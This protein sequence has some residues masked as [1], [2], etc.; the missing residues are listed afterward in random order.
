MLEKTIST[1]LVTY[2]DQTKW[3]YFLVEDDDLLEKYNIIW[4]K[5]SP[6]M[7]KEFDSKPV[8]NEE[9][10]K[11]KKKKKF[12]AMKMQIFIIQIS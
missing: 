3:M 4:D 11:T 12:M 5:V 7:K 8:Y 2:D 9:Y 1:L 10:L 6:D